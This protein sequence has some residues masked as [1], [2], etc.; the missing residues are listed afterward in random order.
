MIDN[1]VKYGDQTLFRRNHIGDTGKGCVTAIDD[2]QPA[3][4]VGW[5]TYAEN[6]VMGTNLIT[7]AQTGAARCDGNLS[8]NGFVAVTAS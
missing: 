7:I 4:W 3:D 8:A 6:T 2:N 1:T 5:A